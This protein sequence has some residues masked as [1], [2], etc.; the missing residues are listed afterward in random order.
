MFYILCVYL[1]IFDVFSFGYLFIIFFFFKLYNMIMCFT[2]SVHYR[3]VWCFFASSFWE[4]TWNYEFFFFF[5]ELFLR[6]IYYIYIYVLVRYMLSEKKKTNY[7]YDQSN[8]FRKGTK[9]RSLHANPLLCQPA[10]LPTLTAFTHT[11]LT[12]NRVWI[13]KQIGWLAEQHFLPLHLPRCRR[14]RK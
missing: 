8:A 1:P 14:F 5:F 11:L 13:E 3:Y 7:D 10:P 4:S 12:N 2:E 6:N 9:W